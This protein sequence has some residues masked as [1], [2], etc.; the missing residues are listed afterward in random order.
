MRRAV[1]ALVL[2]CAAA[3]GCAPAF[4]AHAADTALA[5]AVRVTVMPGIVESGLAKWLIEDF[6]AVRP[7]IRVDVT[8]APLAEAL[9]SARQGEADLLITNH[10]P[11]E[12]MF[13]AD[14]WASGRVALMFG[15]YSFFGPV[16]DKLQILPETDARVVLHKIA[17]AKVP[18]VAPSLTTSEGMRMAELW[19][20][21]GVTADWDGYSVQ[22]VDSLGALR[23]AAAS[24]VYS[25]G[26]AG[27]FIM[28]RKE[29]QLTLQPLTRVIVSLRNH[30]SLV[31]VSAD[32]VAGV[33][34]PLADALGDYLLS[35]R[36]QAR[37]GAFTTRGTQSAL[38]WPAAHQDDALRALSAETELWWVWAA[39]YATAA[40]AVAALAGTWVGFSRARRAERSV[41]R[42]RQIESRFIK[43]VQ[44][45]GLGIWDWSLGEDRVYLSGRFQEIVGLDMNGR[46]FPAPRELWSTI[47][48]PQDVGAMMAAT[49]AA[50]SAG[51]G[52]ILLELRLKPAAAA[53][54]TPQSERRVLLRASAHPKRKGQGA[55]VVGTIEALGMG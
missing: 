11:S 52:P 25:F 41:T 6:R 17:E 16:G 34:Q 48:H 40:L 12:E 49:E 37:I 19:R 30:F 42:H 32:K 15:E 26:E 9:E 38:Y 28:R 36:G 3:F 5:D 51:N 44:A 39:L 24:Q 50:L 13:I 47:L 54:A 31:Y 29:L 22:N 1:T 35:E 46:W 53:G 4:T 7:D 10:R 33:R 2:G 55:R 8:T 27:S 43:A 45:S 23:A 14:G 21:A 20:L 18:F